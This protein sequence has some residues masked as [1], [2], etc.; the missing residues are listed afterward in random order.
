MQEIKHAIESMAWPDT[1]KPHDYVEEALRYAGIPFERALE[2]SCG[3]ID[4]LVASEV[5]V[6]VETPPARGS[7]S[8]RRLGT[9]LESLGYREGVLL[10]AR[11]REAFETEWHTRQAKALPVQILPLRWRS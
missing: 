6:Q 3:M 2:T 5:V 4:F 7:E 10:S 9:L 1:A 11:H 8:F